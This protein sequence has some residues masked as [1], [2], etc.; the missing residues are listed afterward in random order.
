[1][2]AEPKDFKRFQTVKE[3]MER[4]QVS[5]TTLY[6]EMARGRLTKKLIAGCVRFAIEQVER[7]ERTA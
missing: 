5:R 3:L 6:A 7:Y 1:M 4:W 2:N